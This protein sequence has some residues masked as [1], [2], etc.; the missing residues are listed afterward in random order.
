MGE[1]NTV[2]IDTSAEAIEKTPEQYVE[3][4]HEAAAAEQAAAERPDWLPEKFKSP[5]DMA[6]AYAALEQKMGGGKSEEPV[7]EEADP[8]AAPAVPS[9]DDVAGNEQLDLNALETEFRNNGELSEESYEA[10]AKA[11]YS[12]EIVDKYIEGQQ[13]IVERQVEEIVADVGGREGYNDL[14]EWAAD[15][16]SDAEID[17]FNN[18]IEGNDV[19]AIKLAVN[20]LQARRDTG[21]P[22]DPRVQ[23]DGG[24]PA[25]ADVFESWAQVKEAMADPRYSTDPAFNNAVVQKLGRSNL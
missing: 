3:E 5:E 18:V 13:A 12:K 22:K 7:E 10:A 14:V 15:N 20:G 6:Q 24:A 21:A 8:D 19:N 25:A 9:R 17:A 16:L 2:T 1:V 11:G 23:V 4:A